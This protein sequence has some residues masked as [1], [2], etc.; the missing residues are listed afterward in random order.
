M[1]K[2]VA[3][4]GGGIIGMSIAWRLAKR[5]FTV[6]VFEKGQVGAEASWAGA[7]MLAPGGEVDGPSPLAELALKSRLLYAGFVRELEA[8]SGLAIDYQECGALDLAYNDGEWQALQARAQLQQSLGIL[9]KQLT[10]EQV[11]TFWPRVSTFNLHGSLFYAGDAIV[12]PRDVMQALSAACHRSGVAIREHA[13]VEAAELKGNVVGVET[14][15]SADNFDGLVVAA[16][17]WS[18][19]IRIGG[20]DPLPAAKPVKGQL[21]GFHQPDQTCNTILR[22][23]HTYLL[24]RSSGLLI[25]GASV[26]DAGW[27]RT[28]EP[29]VTESLAQQAAFVLPHLA[30]TSPSESWM[31]FRPGGNALHIGAWGSPHI[32]LAYGHYR[33]GILLAPVTAAMAADD[34][35]A[36]LGTP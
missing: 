30:E 29:S 20:G 8:E 9:S 33:N 28:V 35:T 26:E 24:Q 13:P 6:T 32:Y 23:G 11:A 31:G 14:T 36:S 25:A 1:S 34:L 17:P 15:G 10:N 5:G 19:S 16:G 7:G 4:A 21:I 12:N 22:H 27:D 2:S 3:V 18:S